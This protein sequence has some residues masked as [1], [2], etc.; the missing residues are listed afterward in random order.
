MTYYRRDTGR[1]KPTHTSRRPRLLA[2]KRRHL[3]DE[4]LAELGPTRLGVD[5]GA[6]RLA[7]LPRSLVG[8]RRVAILFAH[9]AIDDRA[10]DR[11]AL[12]GRRLSFGLSFGCGDLGHL[13]FGEEDVL[14]RRRLLAVRGLLSGWAGRNKK[15]E[16]AT[17][18]RVVCLEWGYAP[19]EPRPRP[20][21]GSILLILKK[22]CG[23]Q[24]LRMMK[25]EQTVM[26]AVLAR[27][28]SLAVW[29]QLFQQQKTK[30]L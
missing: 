5:L 13:A 19:S 24:Q 27:K 28:V 6:S 9:L 11:D 3:L 22:K 4:P 23:Q 18:L 21:D 26:P 29:F 7:S 8:S 1:A 10:D 15:A 20:P 16:T 2:R 30:P 17:Q 12:D 14:E 25:S